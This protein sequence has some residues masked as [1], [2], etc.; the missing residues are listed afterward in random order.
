MDNQNQAHEHN[1]LDYGDD[2]LKCPCGEF[3]PKKGTAAAD[4]ATEAASEQRDPAQ[5]QNDENIAHNENAGAGTTEAPQDS[6][7]GEKVNA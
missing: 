5:Q 4:K 1:F 2:R 6:T 7:G 3:G